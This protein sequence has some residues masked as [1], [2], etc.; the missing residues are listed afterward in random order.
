MVAYTFYETDNRVRRYAETLV[1]RGDQVD[2][3]VLRRPG[4]TPFDVIR[5]VNVYRIQKRVVDETHPFTYL[6]K[7]LF[8]LLRSFYMLS[9]HH[10]RRHYDLIHVHSIP[11]FEVFSTLIPRLMGAKIILDIH[12]IVPELYASKFKISIKSF[13]FRL[14]VWMEKL[15]VRYSHHVI[16]A[17]H[18]W[19]ERLVSRSASLERCSTILN[20]PDPLIFHSV[21]G[22][23]TQH[24]DEFVMCYPGTLSWHQGVDLIIL[25]VARLRDKAP[26]LRLLVFGD[27]PERDKLQALVKEH[28]LENQVTIGAGVALEQVAEVMRH[29]DLGVEPKR[30]RSFGNEALSTKILEFMAMD[31]PVLASDTLINQRYFSGGLVDFFVSDDVD[32]LASAIFRLMNDSQR[33]ATMRERGLQY[34]QLNNWDAKMHEYLDLVDVLVQPQTKKP[35]PH[36]HRGTLSDSDQPSSV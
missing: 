12:D 3:I 14:L 16:I 1:R 33:C 29:V 11:D 31:V 27:G 30:K 21:K 18:L 2:A 22:P 4:Q 24:S 19:F 13:P 26:N 28:R 25:A 36:F 8:F 23:A 17:N 9:T 32:D 6:A 10:L 35:S 34:I 15:S 5:G 20:Y 7:L